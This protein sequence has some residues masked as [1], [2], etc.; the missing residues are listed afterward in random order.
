MFVA[1]KKGSI[2]LTT[3]LVVSAILLAGGISLIL[4]SIDLSNAAKDTFNSSQ[5]SI[6]SNTCLEE[7]I[8]KLNRS[9]TFTGSLSV[10]YS[11]GE[12]FVVIQ[13]DNNNNQIKIL[14]ITSQV[15]SY[16]HEEVV[17]IDISKNPFEIIK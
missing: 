9:S 14:N 2:T 1:N 16:V 12:C 8:Y 5:T 13:N 4:T 6:R 10:D 3:V 15:N 11:D 7:G 17:R